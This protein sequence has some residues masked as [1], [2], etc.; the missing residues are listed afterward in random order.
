MI[1]NQNFGIAINIDRIALFG[2]NDGNGDDD[3][4]KDLYNERQR[5][6]GRFIVIEKKFTAQMECD[7]SF[8][9]SL[10]R[11]HVV[12]GLFIA[13]EVQASLDTINSAN[14]STTTLLAVRTIMNKNKM[15][16]R[17]MHEIEYE[18]GWDI[19][20][21][22]CS[23]LNVI[24]VKIPDQKNREHIVDI[25]IPCEYP[26]EKPAISI[27]LPIVVNVEW[28]QHY[29]LI[30]VINHIKNLI[31]VHQEY[32]DT[33]DDL[34][35]RVWVLEPTERTYAIAC[36]RI[37]IDKMCSIIVTIDFEHPRVMCD[38]KFLGAQNRIEGIKNS[39][40]NNSNQWN[41]L[42][43][44]KQNLEQVLEIQFI[45]PK[46]HNTNDFNIECNICYSYIEPSIATT[47]V[48][49]AGARTNNNIQNHDG[50]GYD[51]RTPDEI[52]P[53][54]NCNRLYHHSCLKGWL[55]SL[56]S[57]RNSFGTLFGECPYCQESIS[58]VI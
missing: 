16:R 47:S 39:M 43:S 23:D 58:I 2:Y 19:I 37:A 38:I 18:L 42:N 24:S 35:K 31:Y 33:L 9:S 44:V 30:D 48:R 51:G 29:H 26:S 34:D 46:E 4:Y 28:K 7:T 41:V 36:R 10:Q 17:L 11:S 3:G 53:N 54:A 21:S 15:M 20:D 12:N 56:P 50:S 22:I 6:D 14:V 40:V 57:S 49:T 25:Y 5:C 27:K 8:M 32:F 55:Q 52:C 45:S 13:N 1:G